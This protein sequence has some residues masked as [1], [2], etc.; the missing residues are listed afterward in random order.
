MSDIISSPSRFPG[1]RSSRGV[2]RCFE[3]GGGLGQSPTG[4]SGQ[5]PREKGGPGALPRKNFGKWTPKSL[6]LGCFK[7]MRARVD[8]QIARYYIVLQ[9]GRMSQPPWSNF[10][11]GWRPRR[12]PGSYASVKEPSSRKLLTLIN[13][14]REFLFRLLGLLLGSV[15]AVC[16]SA[17][18][19]TI[20]LC[21]TVHAC[22]LS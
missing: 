21:L 11:G 17:A 9:Y 7:K 5:R 15:V 10:R 13:L 14:W 1:P 3:M 19:I 22:W 20:K 18:P 2:G 12:P 16:V 6:I 4:R 8:L